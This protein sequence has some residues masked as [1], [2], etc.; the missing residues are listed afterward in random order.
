MISVLCD[1]LNDFNPLGHC[2]FSCAF[3]NTWKRYSFGRKEGQGQ[4][5]A[6]KVAV[7]P[8]ISM[9]SL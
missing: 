8:W 7:H 3:Q 5:K 2:I 4:N 6:S 9:E 1:P